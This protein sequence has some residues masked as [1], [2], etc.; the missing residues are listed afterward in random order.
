MLRY[1]ETPIL[2]STGFEDEDDEDSLPDEAS[3]L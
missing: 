1:S 2:R 3:G